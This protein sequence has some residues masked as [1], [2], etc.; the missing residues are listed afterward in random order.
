MC[1]RTCVKC[2]RDVRVVIKPNW[3]GIHVIR[4]FEATIDGI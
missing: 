4:R 2:V 3:S 1:H